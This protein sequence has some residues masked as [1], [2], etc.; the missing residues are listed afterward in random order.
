[1]RKLKIDREPSATA[2]NMGDWADVIDSGQILRNDGTDYYQEDTIAD[3]LTNASNGD[4]IFLGPGTYAET[5]TISKSITLTGVKPSLSTT[6]TFSGGSVI[7]GFV[8]VN[9][10]NVLISNLGVQ[11][12]STHCISVG[13]S[14]TDCELDNLQVWGKNTAA[15]GI[16]STAAN[17]IMRNITIYGCASFG[18]ASKASNQIVEGCYIIM[19][20]GASNGIIVKADTGDTVTGSVIRNCEV[21]GSAT[22]AQGILLEAFSSTSTLTNITVMGCKTY[23]WN[24]GIAVISQASGAVIEDC[25]VANC[26][27]EGEAFYSVYHYTPVAGAEIN[28]SIAAYV[29]G[30]GAPIKTGSG[31][32]TVNAVRCFRISNLT[33]YNGAL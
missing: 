12:D 5:F 31:T 25:V 9:A 10:A 26:V 8:G 2:D 3:A 23:L 15:H 20:V 7:D 13:S 1:M 6:G 32:M 28:N 30:K 22:S 19:P 11:D 14:S 21:R 16:E 4:A 33:E 18:I 17:T 29:V 27:T 24:S